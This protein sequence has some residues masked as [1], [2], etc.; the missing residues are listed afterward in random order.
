M[1]ELK[2]S[3]ISDSY[4]PQEIFDQV[5][6]APY[7]WFRLAPD[8]KGYTLPTLVQELSY[9]DGWTPNVVAEFL[10]TEEMVEK[11]TFK[12][13]YEYIVKNDPSRKL[14]DFVEDLDANDV[15]MILQVACFGEVRYS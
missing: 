14:T 9:P 5:W 2:L 15:D 4:T 7:S 1:Y 13:F 6:E 11:A 8:H 12:S 10:I 3:D